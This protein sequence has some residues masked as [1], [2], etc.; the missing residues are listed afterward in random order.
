M[1]DVVLPT[2]VSAECTHLPH[3]PKKFAFLFSA[4]RPFA[5]EGVGVGVRVDWVRPDHPVN[6]QSFAGEIRRAAARHRPA[7]AVG[8]EPGDRRVLEKVRR[9]PAAPHLAAGIRH[10]RRFLCSTAAFAA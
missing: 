7:R 2:E 5:G 9:W 4:M 3:H 1:R 8:S 6:G 10:D